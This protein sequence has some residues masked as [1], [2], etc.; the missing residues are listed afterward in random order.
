MIWVSCCNI[1]TVSEV[2]L[3]SRNRS[4]GT[5]EDGVL[6]AFF[7]N[8][9]GRTKVCRHQ[10][11]IHHRLYPSLYSSWNV[12]SMMVEKN[13]QQE[14]PH[15]VAWPR[16]RTIAKPRK[17][18][19]SWSGAQEVRTK[20]QDDDSKNKEE[21]SRRCHLRCLSA[22]ENFRDGPDRRD[23]AATN[24]LSPVCSIGGVVCVLLRPP[25]VPTPWFYASWS[26]FGLFCF[27]TWHPR[28]PR[29]TSADPPETPRL[30]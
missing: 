13:K 22:D 17:W 28:L 6:I 29:A 24:F 21:D 19:N 18:S 23:V 5:L 14:H 27:P 2:T 16:S 12:D 20:Q 11:K 10:I 8:T 30:I 9:K 26:N 1:P 15:S 4:I 7:Y 25:T 3:N